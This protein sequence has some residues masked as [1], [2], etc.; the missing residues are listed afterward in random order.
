MYELQ[1]CLYSRR[2]TRYIGVRI[3]HSTSKLHPDDAWRDEPRAALDAHKRT[4]SV[5]AFC[6]R[7]AQYMS[8]WR[9]KSAAMLPTLMV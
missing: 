2:G 4:S 9:I 3:S 8:R 6:R 1:H 5:S 7:A